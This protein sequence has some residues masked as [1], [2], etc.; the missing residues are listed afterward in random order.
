MDAFFQVIYAKDTDYDAN[1]YGRPFKFNS[2]GFQPYAFATIPVKKHP[3]PNQCTGVASCE[4]CSYVMNANDLFSEFC[5]RI[6]MYSKPHWHIIR[7]MD[8]FTNLVY[9]NVEYINVNEA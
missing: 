6:K 4:I 7:D 5:Y 1:D 2:N 8:I 3:V 9:G